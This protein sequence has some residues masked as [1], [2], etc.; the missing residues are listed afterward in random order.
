MQNPV[1]AVSKKNRCRR[2]G[3]CHSASHD[4]AE[5]KV[6]QREDSVWG[7]LV[8]VKNCKETLSGRQ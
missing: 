5:T 1:Q 8:G 3:C 6:M 2:H 7:E 4:I